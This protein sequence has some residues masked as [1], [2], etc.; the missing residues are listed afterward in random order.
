MNTLD[1]K[2]KP[3]ARLFSNFKYELYIWDWPVN[4]LEVFYVID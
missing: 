1:T 4:D 3:P 2:L